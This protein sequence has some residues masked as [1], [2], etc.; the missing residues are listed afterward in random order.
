MRS[1]VSGYVS[2]R[3]CGVVGP[4]GA[5]GAGRWPWGWE[6]TIGGHRHHRQTPNPRD[7]AVGALGM[8]ARAGGGGH[9][10][11]RAIPVPVPLPSPCHRCPSAISPH[12]AVVPVPPHGTAIPMPLCSLCHWCCPRAITIPV[13]PLS[14]CHPC[15][16]ASV[17]P[18]P[19]PPPCHH[20][21][22]ATAAPIPLLSPCHHHPCDAVLPV[23]LLSIPVPPPSPCHRPP[24]P[25]A[26]FPPRAP[27]PRA[28]TPFP[29]PH[30]HRSP[31]P[32]PPP[33]PRTALPYGDTAAIPRPRAQQR[34]AAHRR[35]ILGEHRRHRADPGPPPAPLLTADRDPGM[36]SSSGSAPAGGDGGE[37]RD[38]TAPG[39]APLH[40]T[41]PH[42]APRRQWAPP[43]PQVP[44]WG[45]GRG[46]ERGHRPSLSRGG[47]RSGMGAVGLGW[48]GD[49]VGWGW[50]H[51]AAGPGP[52]GGGGGV[53]SRA[54]PNRAELSRAE[55]N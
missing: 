47:A 34:A 36:R 17:V 30:F 39:G 20:C 25:T 7:E 1:K 6:G 52:F 32:S 2:L 55:P 3:D 8:V 24:G 40:P 48:D 14:L 27:T 53:P 35:P 38:V 44:L 43:T 29:A 31:P 33:R 10:G 9:C 50:T 42:P 19:S 49:G 13:P 15:P 26:V 4:E 22:F 21:P 11:P 54:G 5:E 18:V 16:H 23:P 41:P 37:Q 45:V 12:A 28:L 51:R 46:G